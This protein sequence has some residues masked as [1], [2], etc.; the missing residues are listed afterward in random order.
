MEAKIKNFIVKNLN[1]DGINNLEQIL[2]KLDSSKKGVVRVENAIEI[3]NRLALRK[4]KTGALVSSF[5][6]SISKPE[7]EEIELQVIKLETELVV[8]FTFTD[9]KEKEKFNL[10]PNENLINSLSTYLAPFIKIYVNNILEVL[11]S[12]GVLISASRNKIK[13][14]DIEIDL[15]KI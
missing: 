11:N 10:I 5:T 4:D 13:D 6:E 1:Y 8:E 7:N 15:D 3:S 12:N 9:E 2:K 14:V